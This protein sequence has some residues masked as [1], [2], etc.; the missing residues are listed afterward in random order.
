MQ[1]MREMQQPFFRP[2][3]F[4]EQ[5]VNNNRYEVC[6]NTHSIG[7]QSLAK[8][9]S[10]IFVFVR[11]FFHVTSGLSYPFLGQGS[12]VPCIG[13]IIDILGKLGKI[14]HLLSEAQSKHFLLNLL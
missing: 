5:N 7:I 8:S 11:V 14:V 2:L 1:Q 10:L 3:S 12:R 4:S 9:F 6:Q 13:R